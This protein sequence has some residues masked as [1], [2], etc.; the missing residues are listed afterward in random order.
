METITI[1]LGTIS[2]IILLIN[3]DWYKAVN[4]S[5]KP[6][7]CALCMGFWLSVV[8]L[9]YVYGWLGPLYAAIVAIGTEFIDRKLN[10]Y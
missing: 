9:S 4:W 2:L 7:S 3:H 1:L 6:F 5:R 10:Q 8:P